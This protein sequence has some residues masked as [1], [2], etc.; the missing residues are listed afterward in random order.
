[1][2]TVDK[3]ND[4]EINIQVIKGNTF[5]QQFQILNDA[6]LGYIPCPGDDIMFYVFNKYTDET[7]IYSKKIPYNTLLLELKAKETAKMR[8]N[9]YVY[10]IRLNRQ[11]GDVDD[12]IHG[13]FTVKGMID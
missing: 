4:N 6:R 11:N 3:I 10:K 1:M 9:D 12:F 8:I 2:Y 7:P 13:K 5:R